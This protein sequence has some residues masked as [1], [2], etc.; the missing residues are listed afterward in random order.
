MRDYRILRTGAGVVIELRTP[1]RV[2]MRQWLYAME[3]GEFA[4]LCLA[5]AAFGLALAIR[6]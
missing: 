4:A 3:D 6:W 2:R 1:W 5:L